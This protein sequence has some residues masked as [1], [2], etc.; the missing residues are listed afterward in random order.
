MNIEYGSGASTKTSKRSSLTIWLVKINFIGKDIVSK[1]F[2]KSNWHQ[3]GLWLWNLGSF[4]SFKFKVNFIATCMFS[5]Q[6]QYM[7]NFPS[8][9][10]LLYFFPS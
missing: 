2:G 7:V 3:E 9:G 8:N 10:Y 1:S 5:S 4:K 6:T